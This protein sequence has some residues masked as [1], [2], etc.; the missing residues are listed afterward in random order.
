M[1][2]EG[3]HNHLDAW[4]EAM[5]LVEGVYRDT[6]C[7]PAREAFGL[8]AQM[9]RAAVSI[10]SNLAEG[11]AR[12]SRKEFVHF[13]GICCGSLAELETQLQLAVR[14]RYLAGQAP[15]ISQAA[16]VGQLL[17]GLRRYLKVRDS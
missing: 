1:G 9:R 6:E 15:C 13:V 11:A 7:F 10:P 8:T 17:G 4:R 2:I 3:T 5:N 12:N 16:R 14:L